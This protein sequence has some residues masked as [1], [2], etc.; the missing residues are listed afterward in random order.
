MHGN[1]KL[2][3]KKS[4]FLLYKPKLQYRPL[5]SQ[6]LN[7]ITPFHT[8]PPHISN[9]TLLLSWR[10][11]V[12]LPCGLLH[13][14]FSTKNLYAFIFSLIRATCSAHLILLNCITWTKFDG[15][16]KSLISSLCHVSLPLAWPQISPSAPHSRTLSTPFLPS[17]RETKFQ[18]RTKQQ[19]KL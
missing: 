2:K 13:L 11:S 6:P 14:G 17:V 10:L 1:T 18:T 12:S 9:S 8:L 16:Y 3:F 5:K 4:L 19:A 7:Q 15:Q